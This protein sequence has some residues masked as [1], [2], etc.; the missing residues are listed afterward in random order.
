MFVCLFDFFFSF[1]I[2]VS[3][4]QSATSAP[5]PERNVQTDVPIQ[6]RR[7][8]ASNTALINFCS[9]SF[10]RTKRKLEPD[11]TKVLTLD[12]DHKLKKASTVAKSSE[13]IGSVNNVGENR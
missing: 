3:R 13:V 9:S 5:P 11:V 7:F 1:Q 4:L 2:G 12:S 8:A 6:G 10:V